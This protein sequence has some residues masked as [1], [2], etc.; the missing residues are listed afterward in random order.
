LHLGVVQE[1]ETVLNESVTRRVRERCGGAA[2]DALNWVGSK[3]ERSS[4][5]SCI[6]DNCIVG[7]V[8]ELIG[9]SVGGGCIVRATVT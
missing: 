2:P 5:D 8:V 3:G 9:G 1:E 6:G 4:E 7:I